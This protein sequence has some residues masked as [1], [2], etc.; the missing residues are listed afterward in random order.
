MARRTTQLAARSLAVATNEPPTA[1]PPWK[2]PSRRGRTSIAAYLDE[3]THQ[4]FRIL[5]LEL[6]RSG[7]NLLIEALNDLFKK[8]GKPPIAQ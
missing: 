6:K 2:A 5:S 3:Q 7:Q 1:P 4:Q 8:Y